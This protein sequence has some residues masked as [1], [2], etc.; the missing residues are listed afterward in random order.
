M[1]AVCRSLQTDSTCSRLSLHA[2]SVSS[3]TTWF[4]YIAP[5]ANV[6]QGGMGGRVRG[7]RVV[8]RVKT[9]LVGGEGGGGHAAGWRRGGKRVRRGWDV[10]RYSHGD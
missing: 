7:G 9:G 3:H 5:P 10:K 1:A 4:T 8:Q 2:P 6:G